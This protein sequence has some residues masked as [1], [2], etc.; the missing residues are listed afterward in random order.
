[1]F[2]FSC[3]STCPFPISFSIFTHSCCVRVWVA[4]IQVSWSFFSV[5]LVYC[6][7]PDIPRSFLR[8]FKFNKRESSV[9]SVRDFKQNHDKIKSNR[10]NKDEWQ[11]SWFLTKE[12]WNIV[13]KMFG[14]CAFVCFSFF[15]PFS[16]D[17][18]NE[19]AHIQH[20]V[21]IKCS[22]LYV[23]LII[24]VYHALQNFRIFTRAINKLWL[25]YKYKNG[26]R[27]QTFV[28]LDYFPSLFVFRLRDWTGQSESKRERKLQRG[29]RVCESFEYIKCALSS[30]KFGCV[31]LSF[32]KYRCFD[33]I[34]S[35]GRANDSN[36]DWSNKTNRRIHTHIPGSHIQLWA[37][38]LKW[39]SLDCLWIS[40]EF[41]RWMLLM[42]SFCFDSFEANIFFFVSVAKCCLK[43]IPFKFDVIDRI[44]HAEE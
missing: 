29:K 1:M 43:S 40:T 30:S 26:C 7:R 4:I 9:N 12:N 10:R 25:L 11:S 28:T 22:F 6:V 27:R 32:G 35:G 3:L 13:N 42:Q 33:K 2:F 18:R 20:F 5:V 36:V 24:S 34:K 23:L 44:L 17:K 41:M 37:D 21:P 14:W 39:Q 8:A 19:S 15:P 31:C 38:E 16:V